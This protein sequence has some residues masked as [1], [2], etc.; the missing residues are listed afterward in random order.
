ME[1]ESVAR[2]ASKASIPIGIEDALNLFTIEE[3]LGKDEAW[4]CKQCKDFRL[5]K[6]KLD[7]WKLPS[8][9]IIHLKRFE[10]TGR[11]FTKIVRPVLYDTDHCDFSKY[12]AD[13]ALVGDGP[14]SYT[15]LGVVVTS[16][17]RL[18]FVHL[19]FPN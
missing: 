12:C 16:F 11:G 15:L 7:V 4:Y 2:N 3:M 1:H 14:I 13:P 6:K 10:Y 9:L 19:F 18:P 8:F 17:L 5:A